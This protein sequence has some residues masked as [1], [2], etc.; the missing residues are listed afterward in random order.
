MSKRILLTVGSLAALAI[1]AA[2]GL[3]AA[4][5]WSQNAVA[6]AQSAPAATTSALPRT[7]TVVGTG[8]VSVKPDIATISVGIQVDS[9]TVKEATSQA[10]QQMDKILA[11]LKAQGVAEK[12]IQTNNYS[13]NY[14]TRAL[15]APSSTSKA[16]SSTSEPTGTYHVSNMVQV[17]VRDLKKVSAIVDEVINAGANSLWGINFTLEDTSRVASEARAKAVADAKSRAEEFAKLA[18]AK[19][20]PALQI[21]EVIGGGSLVGNYMV[22]SAAKFGGGGGPG[23]VSQ[24]ELEIQ[25]QVQVIYAME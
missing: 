18:G 20:G 3:Q 22:D 23:A 21:S 10:S 11:A 19:V 9:P 13:I 24:G 4:G 16:P 7:I 17:K 1:L 15:L 8:K 12:D 14:E 5:V 2:L 6:Q 25:F